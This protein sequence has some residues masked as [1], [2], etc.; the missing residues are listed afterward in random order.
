MPIVWQYPDGSILQ[1]QFVDVFLGRERRDG[2][3][4]EAA[5][6]RLGHEHVEKKIPGLA[7]LPVQIVKSADVPHDRS[8]RHAWRLTIADGRAKVIVDPTVP[9]PPQS[10]RQQ[11][12]A[13]LL[14][15]D[16]KAV[17]PEDLP[18]IM[19]RLQKVL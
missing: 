8:T 6:L 2:E 7:G 1:Y 13:E 11:A 16:P 5:V 17:K 15:L 18:G 12:R 10:R 9:D 3:T 14:A 19:E 4:T